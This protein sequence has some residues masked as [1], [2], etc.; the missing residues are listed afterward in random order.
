MIDAKGLGRT[1][2]K[3]LARIY[4]KP[5]QQ[6]KKYVFNQSD[7]YALYSLM[8]RRLIGRQQMKD[9]RTGRKSYFYFPATKVKVSVLLK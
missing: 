9:I 1:Q 2:K 6:A 7:Q 8:K 4:A 5:N 3:M